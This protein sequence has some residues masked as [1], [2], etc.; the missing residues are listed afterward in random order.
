MANLFDS[1]NYPETEPLKI[2]SV[3]ALRGNAPILALIMRQL[4]TALNIL[5][6]LKAAAQ[7]HLILQLQNLDQITL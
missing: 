7:P 2:I 3:I 6:A 5:R 4:L 1:T